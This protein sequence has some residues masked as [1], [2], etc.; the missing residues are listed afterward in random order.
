M[1]CMYTTIMRIAVNY[2]G[3]LLTGKTLRKTVENGGTGK[4]KSIVCRCCVEDLSL[5]EWWAAGGYSSS[6]CTHSTLNQEPHGLC[7]CGY[8]GTDR[9][10]S[11]RCSQSDIS[12]WNVGTSS[13]IYKCLC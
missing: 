11:Q 8:I 6:F 9:C 3:A 13:H 2:S 12:C 4:L 7:R 1:L 10:Y 5:E